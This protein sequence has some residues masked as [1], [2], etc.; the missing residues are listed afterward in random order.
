ME[1]AWKKAAYLKS[2]MGKNLPLI[3]GPRGF[4]L[5]EIALC[6]RS[7]SGKSS[8]LNDLCEQKTL[9]RVSN[10]PGKTQLINF[11]NVADRLTLVDLPGYGFAKVPAALKKEWAEALE[12][13]FSSRN[14]LFLLLLLI[15]IRR[16]PSDEDLQMMEWAHHN[17]KKVTLVLTKT[18]KVTLQENK[19]NS[20]EILYALRY[21]PLEVIHYSIMTHE[22]RKMLRS[23]ISKELLCHA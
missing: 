6:G 1:I 11:F 15:D 3:K 18:D 17:N 9:A 7:N 13:Y 16:R 20:L 22:G 12:N 21:K 8:L 5:P 19:K 10:T 2:G 23:H 4:E 14:T